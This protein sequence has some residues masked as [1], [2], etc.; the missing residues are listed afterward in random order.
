MVKMGSFSSSSMDFCDER[1]HDYVGILHQTSSP[2][3]IRRDLDPVADLVE[4]CFAETLDEDGKRYV[5]QMHSA[6]RNPGYLRWA[7]A[8]ADH[9]SIHYLDLSGRKKAGCGK[10]EP[11]PFPKSR[12]AILPDRQCGRR[13]QLSAPGN[14]PR[15]Y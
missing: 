7:S 4:T 8:V 3:D 2:F 15:A 9:A 5:R 14:R 6:A 11:D 10:P 1:Y 13:S 12:A